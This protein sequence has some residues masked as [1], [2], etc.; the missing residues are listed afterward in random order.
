[1]E[2]LEASIWATKLP[3]WEHTRTTIIGY[4]HDERSFA[5]PRDGT[6]IVGLAPPT[7]RPIIVLLYPTARVFTPHSPWPSITTYRAARADFKRQYSLLW[8]TATSDDN[9]EKKFCDIKNCDR[10]GPAG[11]SITVS[12]TV[13][14]AG[15]PSYSKGFLISLEPIKVSMKKRKR[16]R[17]QSKD[18]TGAGDGYILGLRWPLHDS[19]FLSP[20]P[21]M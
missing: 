18:A 13:C 1:M 10:N 12:S 4:R 7:L 5:T 3:A 21:P 17:K 6:W 2:C 15:F 11:Q 16:K 19:K 9:S 20:I 14:N 8:S